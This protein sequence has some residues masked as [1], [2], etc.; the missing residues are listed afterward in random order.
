MP[1]EAPGL[2][3]AQ[4][5]SKILPTITWRGGEDRKERKRREEREERGGGEERKE[6]TT[7]EEREEIGRAHV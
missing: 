5:T 3:I 4:I 2:I 6:K 1:N 7:R